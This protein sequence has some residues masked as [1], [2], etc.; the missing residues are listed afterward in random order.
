VI[1]VGEKEAAQ[2]AVTLRDLASGE[3]RLV[4]CADLTIFLK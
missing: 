1:I 3:Q 4:T 2:G